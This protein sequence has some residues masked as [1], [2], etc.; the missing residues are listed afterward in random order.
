MSGGVGFDWTETPADGPAASSA[1]VRAA[2]DGVQPG[3]ASGYQQIP[4]DQAEDSGGRLPLLP[5]PIDPR[6]QS[7]AA[8]PQ[9]QPQYPAAA[10]PYPGQPQTG[11]PPVAAYPPPY[12]HPLPAHQ[13]QPQFQQAPYVE[14]PAQQ[15][16]Y[17]AQPVAPYTQ[18]PPQSWPGSQQQPPPFA[19]QSQGY[20]AQPSAGFPVALVFDGIN[21]DGTPAINR[22]QLD[23]RETGPLAAYLGQA[24]VALAA[25]GGLPDELLPSAPPSV[26]RAYHT[27]GSWIWPAAVAYYLSRYQLPPQPELLSHI[28]S[29]G[30]QLAAVPEAVRQAAAAQIY[31]GINAAAQ[32]AQYAHP[33]PQP[34]QPYAAYEAAPPAAQ[35]TP[36]EP[37]Q[38]AEPAPRP[39]ASVS[40]PAATSITEFSDAFTKAGNRNAAWVIEQTQALAAYLPPGEWTA[41]HASR[42]YTRSG[43]QITVDALGTLSAAG[44][45]TWAWADEDGWGR[46]SAITGQSR[47]LRTLAESDGVPE[48]TAPALDLALYA[49]GPQ[50]AAELIAL[51]ATGLLAARGYIGHT[52]ADGTAGRVYYV[53]CDAE[54]PKAEPGLG[55]VPRWLMDGAAVFGRDAAECVLGYVEHHGWQWS[56]MPDGLVVTAEGIGSFTV[57]VSAEGRLTGLSLHT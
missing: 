33:Q 3:Y 20:A 8:Q 27:D 15:Y 49:D 44:V 31:A 41:D 22:P 57:E 9:P 12:Q 1:G 10:A 19:Q 35:Y 13:P 55:T 43:R 32:P 14:P 45:W 26:P 5:P 34:P 52:A 18:Q 40:Q 53:V 30:Y 48:L 39:T 6:I 56:R 47:R 42:R 11:Q 36:D 17:A 16:P 2:E 37:T 28:R 51:A 29:R 25:P 38:P 54:V 7:Y 23:P 46:E 4:G 50:A 24:P 21:P